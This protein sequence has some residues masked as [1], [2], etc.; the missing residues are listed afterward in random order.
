MPFGQCAKSGCYSIGVAT[1][2]LEHIAPG[3]TQAIDLF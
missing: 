3:V 1:F 2:E